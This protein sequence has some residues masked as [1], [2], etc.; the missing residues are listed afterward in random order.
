MMKQRLFPFGNNHFLA[1]RKKETAMKQ[2]GNNDETMRKQRWNNEETTMKQAFGLSLKRLIAKM[3]L[4]FKSVIIA[5]NIPNLRQLC[6]QNIV[7]TPTLVSSLFPSCFL[8]VS[9]LFPRSDMSERKQCGNK[10][11]FIIC[12][13]TLS[14][15]I[16]LVF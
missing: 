15:I 16:W 7:F 3:S 12:V 8:V 1:F 4:Q 13:Y 10:R 9:T 6:V 5:S 11:C 14:R 2:W